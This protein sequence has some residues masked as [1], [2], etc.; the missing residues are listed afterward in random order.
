MSYKNW[1]FGF[2]GHGSIGNYAFND[3]WSTHSTS[4]ININSG[5]IG[6]Y[7]KF[8]DQHTTGW[9]ESNS[10]EQWASDL[11]LE[12]ASF[13][14]LDD[15]NLGYTFENINKSG[16]NLRVAAGVQNVFVITKYSG[17]DPEVSSDLGI[18]GTIWPRPRIFSLRLNLNF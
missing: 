10:Q 14:R 12:N 13:F 15:I 16:V 3:I 17:L 2:N 9:V 18:D 8:D 11:F 6:N 5:T 7:I 1:D 4:Y